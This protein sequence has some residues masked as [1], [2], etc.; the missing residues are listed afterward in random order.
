MPLTRVLLVGG[1]MIA[2][3][4]LLPAL[5][6]MQ[7]QGRIGEIAVCASRTST[8]R[9]LGSAAGL[10][11][12]FPGQSFRAYPD[13]DGPPQPQ[14]FREVLAVLPPRQ[15]VIVAVPDQLHYEVV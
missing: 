3:D 10:L 7:R 5:Y 2:H 14:L 11:S 1:G 8:V 4:Q 13:R 9:S 15:I 12:A 6:H